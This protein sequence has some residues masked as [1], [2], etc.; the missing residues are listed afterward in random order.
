MSTGA[1]SAADNTS[2]SL[3]YDPFAAK[4]QKAHNLAQ[5]HTLLYSIHT[6]STLVVTFSNPLSIPVLLNAVFPVLSGVEHSVYP[7]SV[8]IP[9]NA[10]QY[11]IELVFTAK[12]LGTLV[13][14]GVQFVINNATH[15]LRV[16]KE[17]NYAD[18]TR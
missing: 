5:Q 17:G 2:S 16:D 12:S 15:L 13:V 10:E 14:Q 7:I 1:T 4:R 11:T 3:F 9:S 8:Q 6:P 18:P